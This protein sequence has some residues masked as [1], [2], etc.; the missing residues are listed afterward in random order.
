MPPINNVIKMITG[1]IRSVI[2]QVLKRI[3]GAVINDIRLHSYLVFGP[4]DRLSIHPTSTVQNALFNTMSGKIT[5][6][7]K[8]FFGHNVSVLT[9]SHDSNSKNEKRWKPEPAVNDIC[10]MRG[11][12]VAS[13]AVIIGPCVVGE[14]AVVAAGSIVIHDVPP[15]AMVAG[16]PARLKRMI[17]LANES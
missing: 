11:A 3:L 15:G 1:K 7:E 17:D 8:A 9:G 5:I 12:W 10:I 6:C 4:A 13:N 14:N 16:N 2:N